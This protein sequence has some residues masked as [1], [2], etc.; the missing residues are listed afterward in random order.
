[1]N[2]N[3]CFFFFFVF[4]ESKTNFKKKK[5]KKKTKT[6]KAVPVIQK[7]DFE[8]SSLYCDLF[9]SRTLTQGCDGWF[10]GTVVHDYLDN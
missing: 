7:L 4:F 1:M 9:L 8:G 3:N 5:K 6:K 2:T 10:L